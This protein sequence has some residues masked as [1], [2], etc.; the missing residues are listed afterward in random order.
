M[1]NRINLDNI[2]LA[3]WNPRFETIDKLE[4]NF[5]DVFKLHDKNYSTKT[6]IEKISELYNEN[7]QNFYEL[8]YSIKDRFH[9]VN[10]KIQFIKNDDHYIVIEGNRRLSCLLI[11]KN[12]DKYIELIP[13][14]TDNNIN[15]ES[16]NPYIEKLS[17]LYL[18]LLSIKDKI[19]T[20]NIKEYLDF[21]EYYVFTKNEDISNSL[22]IKHTPAKPVGQL[23][24]NKGKYYYDIWTMFNN[25]KWFEQEDIDEEKTRFLFSKSKNAMFSDYKKAAF[26]VK[27]FTY[28]KDDDAILRDE[29]INTQP[30]AFEP[31]FIRNTIK[32]TL[33]LIDDNLN[34]KD[35]YDLEFDAK[36]RDYINNGQFKLEH[37][38]SFIKELKENNMQTTRFN[39]DNKNEIIDIFFNHLNL[40]IVNEDISKKEFLNKF[41]LMS[42]NELKSYK[43]II[44]TKK[45]IDLIDCRLTQFHY[46]NGIIKDLKKRKADVLIELIN[47]I[48]HNTNFEKSKFF[49]NAIQS[50]IRTIIEY[51]IKLIVFN[52]IK[53]CVTFD[54]EYLEFCKI[55]NHKINSPIRYISKTEK[56]SLT[57]ALLFDSQVDI[58]ENQEILEE[59]ELDDEENKEV[60]NSQLRKIFKN[61]LKSDNGVLKTLEK[62]CT[63]NVFIK[64]F[65]DFFEDKL[66]ISDFYLFVNSNWTTINTFIHKIFLKDFTK[67]VDIYK[68]I[69]LNNNKILKNFLEIIQKLKFNIVN[70]VIDEINK[71]T[72]ISWE[73]K[74]A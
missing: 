23:P 13:K 16:I 25:E 55:L 48:H 29:M 31:D 19:D 63:N 1:E 24:W 60:K 36:S 37:V 73:G 3:I 21:D 43:K 46:S 66:S 17:K 56:A 18:F 33:N 22:F 27:F 44:R 67:T 47:Q 50:S 41:M 38:F 4:F 14:L 68:K 6:E 40:N 58:P 26:L 15:E 10:E 70:E 12:I 52:A 69:T 30:T 59:D 42:Q 32:S 9:S 34:Y 49:I 64:S 61:L 45:V 71:E 8:F 57:Y 11:M 65:Y 35:F 62:L 53:N 74:I 7:R 20:Q 39:T 2:H 51:V 72:D 28:I 54:N 5:M